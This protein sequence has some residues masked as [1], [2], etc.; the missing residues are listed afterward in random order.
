MSPSADAA[1]ARLRHLG[2]R[3]AQLTTGATGQ[4]NQVRDLLECAWPAV[5]GAAARPFRSASWCAALAVALD[6]GA[7]DPARGRR[8]GHAPVEGAGRPGPPPREATRAGLPV[9]PACFQTPGG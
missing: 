5:L 1:W 2:A 7:G 6:R 3:R 4:V 8:P 9:I